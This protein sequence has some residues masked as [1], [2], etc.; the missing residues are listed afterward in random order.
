MEINVSMLKRIAP[1]LLA[2]TMLLAACGGTPAAPAAP[3]I[4]PA[5]IPLTAAA[6]AETIVAMTAA[7]VPPTP[8][9]PPTEAPSP[10]PLPTFT[11]DPLMFPPTVALHTFP[12]TPTQASSSS[13]D[14]LKPLN[15]AEA[16][17]TK[18]VRIENTTAGKA[19]VSLNLWTPNL[20]GQCGAL[21]YILGK[22]E[23]TKID[24]PAGSWY[25]YAWIDTGKKQSTAEGSFYLGPSKTDDLLRLVIKDH[26]IGLIGP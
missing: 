22:G 15:M 12:P 25:A 2:A 24:I 16:G 23:S 7:A 9:P 3:T 20:F 4:D 26:T 5:G 10:T 17:P 8:V 1:I 11:P 18:K 19:T 14:C 13:G 21:S 6:A